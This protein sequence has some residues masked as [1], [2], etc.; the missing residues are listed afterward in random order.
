LEG[1]KEKSTLTGRLLDRQ[2]KS[3]KPPGYPQKKKEEERPRMPGN[4]SQEKRPN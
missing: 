4:S 3:N 2:R 1:K